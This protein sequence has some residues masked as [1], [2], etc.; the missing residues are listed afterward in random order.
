[1]GS[2]G[3]EGVGAGEDRGSTLTQSAIS[4]SE[5]CSG[6]PINML[7]CCPTLPINFQWALEAA[8]VA[9]VKV[10]VQAEGPY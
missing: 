4:A 1:M 2:Q 6:S 5:I 3:G 9:K 7:S 8:K 10:Q